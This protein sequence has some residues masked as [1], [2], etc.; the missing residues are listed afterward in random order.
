MGN[1]D[2]ELKGN[3]QVFNKNTQRLEEHRRAIVHGEQELFAFTILFKPYQFGML[4]TKIKMTFQQ[5]DGTQHHIDLPI[6]GLVSASH[7]VMVEPRGSN[8]KGLLRQK[9]QADKFLGFLPPS[10]AIVLDVSQSL[11]DQQG[12]S[13]IPGQNLALFMNKS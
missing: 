12:G 6:V 1:W 2:R 7:S 4:D 11:V 10:P 8:L 9:D 5:E 3:I 13:R